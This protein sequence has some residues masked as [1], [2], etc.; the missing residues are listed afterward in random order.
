MPEQLTFDLPSK[1][2]L[3][4]DDFFVSSANAAAVAMVEGWQ[5]WPSRKLLLIGP[6][7]AGKTT[8]IQLILRFYDPDQGH[9]AL[10]DIYQMAATTF[11]LPV[12]EAVY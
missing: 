1:T 7:G 10:D 3:G 5:S 8:I 4:R 9:I 11:G 2:A 12:T 6:S